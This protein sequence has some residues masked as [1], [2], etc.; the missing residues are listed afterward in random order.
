VGEDK[1]Y[2]ELREGYQ[3]EKTHTRASAHSTSST[4]NY[5]SLSAGSTEP[6]LVVLI[7]P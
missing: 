7:C 5:T 2:G 3:G 1:R 4:C 6:P